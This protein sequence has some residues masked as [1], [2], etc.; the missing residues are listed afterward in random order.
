MTLGFD[1]C[2]RKIPWRRTWQLT[3]VFLPEK[4]HGQR[5]LVGCSP[6]GRRESD[7]TESLSMHVNDFNFLSN[8]KTPGLEHPPVN[9]P[10]F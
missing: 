7:T 3:P 2:V 1:P 6:L 9:N 5:R 10:N 8:K 4:S